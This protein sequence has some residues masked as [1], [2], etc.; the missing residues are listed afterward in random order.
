[1]KK[2]NLN[3][4][5]I[6]YITSNSFN[7]KQFI[8][9][10]KN[11]KADY[12]YGTKI[13]VVANYIF[14]LCRTNHNKYESHQFKNP[15]NSNKIIDLYHYETIIL[16]RHISKKFNVSLEWIRQIVKKLIEL[17]VL[18]HT[19]IVDGIFWVFELVKKDNI[20]NFYLARKQIKK[21]QKQK[22]KRTK[23]TNDPPIE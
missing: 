13:L 7:A 9:I 22:K 12:K 6:N 3:Q 15:Y 14:G 11:G 4:I 1:M 18:K 10:N 19:R 2:I 16:Y 23:K 21:P 5:D 20:L 8:F 17:K